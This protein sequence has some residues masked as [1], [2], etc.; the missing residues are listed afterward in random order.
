MEPAEQSC[1]SNAH[2]TETT[3]GQ[4]V[5][6]AAGRMDAAGL[7]F[8]H[9]TACARDEACW[10]ASSVLGLAPDFDPTEFGR[11]LTAESRD[12]LDA[13]LEQ[14]L[15]TRKPLAYLLG[16]AWFAGLKFA[17]DDR[18]L[19]PRS[20]LAE[21]IVGGMRPWLDLD[22]PL[23]VLDIGTGSGCIAAALARHWPKLRLDAVDVSAVALDI[24]RANVARLGV[25]DRV[26]VLASDLFEAVADRRYD[27]I[28]ANPP[29]VPAASMAGLPDEFRHEPALALAGGDDGLDI[30]RRLLAGAADHLTPGGFLLLEVGEAAPA[31]D[32]L[33]GTVSAVWL[34]FEH[35]GDGVVLLDRAACL[36]WREHDES[37][38]PA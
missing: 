9:G 8:G 13:L 5:E 2:V 38:G 37:G 28:I 12:R 20:P 26:R 34:D 22:R 3:L 7:W 23:A 27:L 21:L 32:A 11:T 16:E 10:M 18:V 31:L 25:G 4:W 15:A 19:I 1:A 33:L 14:R 6:N 29:Y 24:A 36:A 17:V 35:G 30:V